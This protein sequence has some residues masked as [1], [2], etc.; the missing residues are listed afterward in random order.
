MLSSS[1]P[2]AAPTNDPERAHRSMLTVFVGLCFVVSGAYAYE[3]MGGFLGRAREVSAVV[4]DVVYESTNRKGR[5]HPVV[6]FT[7]GTGQEITVATQEHH[8]VQRGE[9]VQ[10]I[11]DSTRPEVLEISTLARAK[12]RRLFIT[13]LSVLFG[14]FVCLMG[15]GLIRLPG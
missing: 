2:P 7:T 10:L 12:K 8:N 1:D 5:T 11:Y 6:R 13:V 3:H 15:L 4:V 14:A 9:T